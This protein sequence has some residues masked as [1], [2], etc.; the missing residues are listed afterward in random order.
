MWS[1]LYIGETINNCFKPKANDKS[2]Q[3]YNNW[4]FT[5]HIKSK[6][7][8]RYC[9]LDPCKQDIVSFPFFLFQLLKNVEL[10]VY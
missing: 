6:A 5:E 7:N 10:S 1:Y 4:L 3:N 8:I 9:G 2:M